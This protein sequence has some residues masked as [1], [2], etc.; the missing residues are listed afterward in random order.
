MT[1]WPEFGELSWDEVAERMTGRL[2]V[3][4]RNMLDP[5]AVTAAG[6]TYEGIGRQ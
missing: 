5:A 1:E 4:G 6:L 2:V 3:D